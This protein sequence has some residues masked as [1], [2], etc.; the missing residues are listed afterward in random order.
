MKLLVDKVRRLPR[1][2][3]QMVRWLI[4]L[5]PIVLGMLLLLGL[6]FGLLQLWRARFSLV[7]LKL[8]TS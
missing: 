7:T 2:S 6:P 3:G 1:A 4:A 5:E 8:W